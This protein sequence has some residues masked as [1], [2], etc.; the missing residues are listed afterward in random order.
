MSG[1]ERLLS[2]WVA[3]ASM[4]VAVGVLSIRNDAL[5]AWLGWSGIVIAVGLVVAR[6]FW[7]GSSI[8][9]TPYG[10]FWLWLIAASIVLVRR[11]GGG[12]QAG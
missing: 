12:Q 10:I 8:V 4:L 9:F 7:V 6:A 3:L 1:F 2:L 11:A 5:P